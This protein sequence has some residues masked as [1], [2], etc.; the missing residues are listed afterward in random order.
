MSES[1]THG[2]VDGTGTGLYCTV[3]VEEVRLVIC[4]ANWNQLFPHVLCVMGS[5]R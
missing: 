3:Y 5:G 4:Y 1:Y 2:A